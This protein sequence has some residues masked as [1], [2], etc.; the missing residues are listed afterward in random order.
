MPWTTGMRS[1]R[2]ARRELAGCAASLVMGG[3][4]LLAPAPALAE[5]THVGGGNAGTSGRSEPGK[6]GKG[7]KPSGRSSSK[8]DGM[9]CPTRDFWVGDGFGADRGNRRH[10]GIDLGGDRGVPIYAVEDGRI[11]RTKRQENGAL[12][13]VMRGV[14]GS[15]FYYGHMD[16]VLVTGGQR[17]RAGDVIGTMGDTG[18]PGAVHLHFEYWKSGGESDAIDPRPLIERICRDELD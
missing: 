2:R 6:A 17:V 12:Q 3:S 9:A 18:S 10:L 16:E 1:P 5:D 15:K 4:L 13:I 14:S 8:G 7:G 11:D